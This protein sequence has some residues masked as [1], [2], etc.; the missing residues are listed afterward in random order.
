MTS[1]AL[2]GKLQEHEIE[3]GRL[4][5]HEAQEK[6]IKSIALNV[7]APRGDQLEEEELTLLVK[8]FGK[9]LK[10]NQNSKFGN[11][12][13]FFKE[14]EASKPNQNIT[15]FECGKEGHIKAECPN[16]SKRNNFKKEFKRAY[17]AWE[18]NEISPSS[19][20]D[21]DETENMTLMASHDSDD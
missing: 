11:K 16:L 9:F 1:A 18:D 5:E 13:R 14:K 21:N 19:D 6:K 3:L 20:S 17:M 2:F 7:E 4:E 8:K 15:C 12:K 10:K